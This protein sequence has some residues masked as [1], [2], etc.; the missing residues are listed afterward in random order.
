MLTLPRPRF[1]YDENGN[2]T[3]VLLSLADYEAML[4]ALEDAEDARIFE[5]RRQEGGETISLEAF[6]EELRLEGRLSG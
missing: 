1:V 3:D 5:E 2:K 6:K 4:E